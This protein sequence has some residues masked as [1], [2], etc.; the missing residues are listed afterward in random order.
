MKFRNI[1][2]SI[3]TV[4]L[5]IA[6]YSLFGS[7]NGYWTGRYSENAWGM[8]RFREKG[9]HFNFF[10]NYMLPFIIIYVTVFAS[11]IW[12][13]CSL[14]DKYIALQNWRNAIISIIGGILVTWGLFV[15]KD[16]LDRP[17]EDNFLANALYR[18][19]G[20]LSP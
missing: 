20:L 10:V 8:A 7:V 13:A 18:E 12:M 17:Y 3:A 6:I 16:C 2:I 19:L 14:P 9:L 11:F 15:I 1:E 5:L 4:L